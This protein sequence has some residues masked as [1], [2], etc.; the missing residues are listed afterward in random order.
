MKSKLH[1]EASM[2]VLLLLGCA[3]RP[4]SAAQSAAAKR[5]ALAAQRAELGR[6]ELPALEQHAL[7]LPSSTASCEATEPPQI[8]ENEAGAAVVV[9]IGT[10]TTIRCFLPKRVAPAADVLENTIRSASSGVQ[11]RSLE[12]SNV[13]LAGV[14][15]AT[16]VD[17]QYDRVLDDT[18][19]PGELKLML[20][21]RP[22]GPL[23][24]MHDA[25]GYRATFERISKGFAASLTPI[26][27]KST[28]PSTAVD[29][30]RQFQGSTTAR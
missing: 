14:E 5:D 6:R 7:A 1:P 18:T 20:F 25:I 29:L 30:G 23:L 15:P 22:E 2:L 11:V 26:H 28:S 19:E 4:P 13:A 21:P 17:M 8:V 9:P 10:E 24:C 27:P 16:L 3:A 12:R